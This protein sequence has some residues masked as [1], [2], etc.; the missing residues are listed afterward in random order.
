MAL[1]GD[2]EEIKDS[3]LLKL[4]NIFDGSYTT[5]IRVA[6]IWYNKIAEDQDSIEKALKDIFEIEKAEE[7]EEGQSSGS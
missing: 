2:I 1:Q 4:K 3:V 6:S 5:F 7:D